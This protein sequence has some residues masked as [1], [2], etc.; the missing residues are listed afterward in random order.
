[1]EAG[2]SAPHHHDSP[3]FWLRTGESPSQQFSFLFVWVKVMTTVG[4]S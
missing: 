1:M 3:E 4:K 2:V